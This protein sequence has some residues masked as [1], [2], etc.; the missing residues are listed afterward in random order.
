MTTAPAGSPMNW[1][2]TWSGKLVSP[3]EAV[4]QVHSG[5]RLFLT[6]NCS[7]PRLLLQ[8]LVDYAPELRDVEICQALTVA[9]SEYVDP[10]LQGHLKVN[11]LFISRNVR[12]AIQEGRADFTPVL[13]SELPR[14]FQSGV[15]PVDVAF[16]HISPPDRHGF[17]SLGI[18][19]GLTR[20]AAESAALIIAEINEQ[21]PRMLGDTFI[22]MSRIDRAVAADYPLAELPMA[23]EGPDEVVQQIARLIAERIPDGATIQTGIGAIP[24]S[25]LHYLRNHRD[26]G[27][28]S[29]LFSDGVIDLVEAGIIN[30]ARKSLHPGK[31][32][33]GFLIGTN[34]LYR[35][36]DDNPIIELRRTEYVNSP[37]TIAQNDRMVAINSAL[38]VDLTG[39]V[40][41]DSI[42]SRLY[43]GVGGQMD[44]I[45]GAGLAREGLPIIAMPSTSILHDGKM[46]SRIVATLKPGAGVTTTRNH[47]HYVVTEYGM[48]DLYGKS[49]AQRAQMLISIAHPEFRD[50]LTHQARELR[51]L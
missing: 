30:G 51:F 25:V 49:I 20:S 46:V 4:R 41:A 44:F 19:S 22:H 45:Y 15:L 32:I 8:A 26:L 40:C 10:A 12:Q 3:E 11:S 21:M 18:E 28:H 7:V 47:V 9:G 23:G 29:E 43:S 6:G 48:V 38:E 16:I 1:K 50:L 13:L 2:E 27:V 36:A 24:D 37:F 34:R 31:M 5:N 14:L 39:Q 17:C 35:W 42:G 33:A